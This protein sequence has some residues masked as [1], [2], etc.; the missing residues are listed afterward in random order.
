MINGEHWGGPALFRPDL[1][2]SFP[3]QAAKNGTLFHGGRGEFAR[4]AW[5]GIFMFVL[6]AAGIF[7]MSG[8]VRADLISEDSVAGYRLKTEN[9]SIQTVLEDMERFFEIKIIGKETVGPLEKAIVAAGQTVEML[10]RDFCRSIGVK[11]YIFIYGKDRLSQVTLIGDYVGPMEISVPEISQGAE[12]KEDKEPERYDVDKYGPRKVQVVQV[13]SIPKE[14]DEKNIGLQAGDVITKVDGERAGT[15]EEFET[16][17][18]NCSRPCPLRVIR[19]ATPISINLDRQIYD[20]K[21]SMRTL[22]NAEVDYYFPEDIKKRTE[23]KG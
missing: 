16:L 19:K 5:T 3:D 4:G 17:L 11:N 6:I 13:A 12:K 20:I 15:L 14:S 9:E 8:Q 1:G 10:F 23:K 2:E 21:F 7:A 22:W 18:R